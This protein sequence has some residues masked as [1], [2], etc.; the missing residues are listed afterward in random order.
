[1][2][3]Y[4][5]VSP[6]DTKALEVRSK[7]L[8]SKIITVS[9]S[10]EELSAR[11]VIAKIPKQQTGRYF[12]GMRTIHAILLIVMDLAV[13]SCFG[14]LPLIY[15]QIWTGL[16]ALLF[17]VILHRAMNDVSYAQNVKF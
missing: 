13:L 3:G 2:K 15:M 12:T 5:V 4:I 7:S 11:A 10:E 16:S 8:D 14:L 6:D 17:S 1:M 9:I